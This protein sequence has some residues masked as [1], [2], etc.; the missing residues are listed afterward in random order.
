MHPY[1]LLSTETKLGEHDGA[2]SMLP[3]VLEVDVAGGV[4][5]AAVVACR[6]H[7][8][9]GNMNLVFQPSMTGPACHLLTLHMVCT[10]RVAASLGRHTGDLLTAETLLLNPEHNRP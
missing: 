9:S 2:S 1:L 4:C 10:R 6:A 7:I 3:L 5:G 8:G